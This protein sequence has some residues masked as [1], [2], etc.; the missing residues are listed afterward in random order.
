MRGRYARLR[1]RWVRVAAGDV[2]NLRAGAAAADQHFAD[3]DLGQFRLKMAL[4][5]P[6][7][8]PT[9]TSALRV[10]GVNLTRDVFSQPGREV[11]IEFRRNPGP[12]AIALIVLVVLSL[13]LLLSWTVFRAAGGVG[14]G[15]GE[16]ATPLIIGA[17]VIGGAVLLNKER[18]A[19][20][21]ALGG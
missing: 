11:V 14:E 18:K 5:P 10:G 6:F 2:G 16:A 21:S 17:V 20:R 8:Q 15:L 13:V 7:L 12:L 3:G 4:I 9:L 19:Q 1:Q